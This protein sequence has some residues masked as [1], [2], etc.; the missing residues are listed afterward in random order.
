MH[1]IRIP[2]PGNAPSCSVDSGMSCE[3]GVDGGFSSVKHSVTNCSTEY[4]PGTDEI[5][6]VWDE[7]GPKYPARKQ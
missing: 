4:Q 5:E 3:S 7:A 6:F 1:A 2:I